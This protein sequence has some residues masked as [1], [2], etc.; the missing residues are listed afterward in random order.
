MEGVISVLEWFHGMNVRMAVVSSSSHSWVDGWLDRLDL[1]KYFAEV[2]CKG[3]AKRIKPAPDLFLA[4][5]ENLEVSPADCLVIEDSRNGLL[6]A[7]AAGAKLW[8]VPNRVTAGL[9]FS[10]ADTVFAD[11]AQMLETLQES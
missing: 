7:K 8:I 2:I 4:A 9:D 5:A 11:F 1:R 3:D 10:E 6:A